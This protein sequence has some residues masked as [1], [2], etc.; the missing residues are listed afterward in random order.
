LR[1][2]AHRSG[3]A[4]FV[5]DGTGFWSNYGTAEAIIK[6]G[7][8]LTYVTGSASVAFNIPHESVP[9][10]LGRLAAGPVR[11]RLRM[12]EHAGPT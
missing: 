7:W 10:L 12:P 9:P 11:K 5:D 4:V 3:R 6:A 2:V 1:P 8:Q